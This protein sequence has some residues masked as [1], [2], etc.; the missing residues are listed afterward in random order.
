MN[1]VSIL[2]FSYAGGEPNLVLIRL[3]DIHLS[4]WNFPTITKVNRGYLSWH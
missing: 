2:E 1:S 4:G 3:E